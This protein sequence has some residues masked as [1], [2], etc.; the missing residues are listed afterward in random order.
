[1]RIARAL[2]SAVAAGL[3][4]GLLLLASCDSDTDD[5]DDAATITVLVA[6]TS[7]VAAGAEDVEAGIRRAFDETNAVYANS[8]VA[9]RLVPVHMVEVDYEVA[10]RLETLAH[11]LRPDDGVLDALHAL[12]DEHAADIVLLV[13]PGP[14]VTINAAVMAEPS[15][16]FLIVQHAHLGAPS[17]ALAHEMGHL[18]GARHSFDEDPALEPFPYGHGFRNDSLRTVL[19]GGAQ[20]KVPFFS[21]PG[22]VY[23]GVVLGDSTLHDVARV[24]RESAVY[25]S[26]F[27]GPQTPTTFEPPGTWPVLP[28]L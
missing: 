5:P 15:T 14:G 6:Y 11:L 18:H 25:L 2:H 27:R 16:G 21:G 17:Y 26:N 9:A 3:V 8:G 12:R 13:P 28:D 7:D 22:Q 4:A 24:L 23:E 20:Q 10:D 19:A 1:M